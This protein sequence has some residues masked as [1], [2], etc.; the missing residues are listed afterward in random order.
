MSLPNNATA[1]R[2]GRVGYRVERWI[3]GR[4]AT[5]KASQQS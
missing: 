2:P 5:L 3:Y 1:I 4:T